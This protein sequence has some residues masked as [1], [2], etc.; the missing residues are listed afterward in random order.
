MLKVS[1]T[2]LNVFFFFSLAAQ[3]NSPFVFVKKRSKDRI[4]FEL[5]N[6]LMEVPVTVNGKELTF[7][8][9]TGVG[10]TL[11]FN[12][13][14]VA[15]V[16]FR[17]KNRVSV[18]GLGNGNT[19]SAQLTRGNILQIGDILG[20][21]LPIL[22]V[23]DNDFEFT[24][25]MGTQIDGILGYAFF[26]QFG[27]KIDYDRRKIVVNNPNKPFR[28][29]RKALRYPLLMHRDK[30]HINLTLSPRGDQTLS[31]PFL[32]DTGSSDAL[33]VFDYHSSIE[34]IPPV[35][36]D[37]LGRGING[38]IF[39][40]RGKIRSINLGS[41]RLFDVKVAYPS[42]KNFQST[43]LLPGRL[44]SL[45]GELLSRFT[46]YLDYPQQQMALLPNT[47]V[48]APFYY[49]LSGIELL[50]DGL[51]LVSKSVNNAMDVLPDSSG[52]QQGVSFF[53]R[54]MT[55]YELQNIVK[56]DEVRPQSPAALVGVKEGDIL[57]KI[58]GR[59]VHR[60]K[61]HQIIG[62]LQRKPGKKIRLNLR[63]QDEPI[64]LQFVLRPLFDRTPNF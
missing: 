34:Q 30:P 47:D 36:E 23:D 50:F 27:V 11:L 49:N 10:T 25:R 40:T 51:E 60:L 57:D 22:L 56:V 21:E 29:P 7:L 32:I 58:N 44:G 43:N 37:Y 17:E 2:L 9:D 64:E 19:L 62:L 6:N 41:I 15:T 16:S 4:S 42:M 46:L 59:S 52:N 12:N 63:R 38:N 33:W 31:G 3:S 48:D 1:L 53:L 20:K 14:R 45:G 18:T 5:I 26:R 54:N 35:F 13:A 24:R 28:I 39:G 8:L 61:L 55:R